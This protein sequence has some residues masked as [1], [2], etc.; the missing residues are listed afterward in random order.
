MIN[1]WDAEIDVNEPLAGQLL[2]SQFQELTPLAIE[3]LGAGWDNIAF[4]VNQSRS[5]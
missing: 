2:S 4:P 5:L 1:P 3:P